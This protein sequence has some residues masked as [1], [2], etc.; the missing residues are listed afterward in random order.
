MAPRLPIP[1][2]PN[3]PKGGPPSSLRFLTAITQ[4]INASPSSQP[5]GN[6]VPLIYSISGFLAVFLVRGRRQRRTNYPAPLHV[7]GTGKC[8]LHFGFHRPYSGLRHFAG[9]GSSE[10]NWNRCG[11]VAFTPGRAGHTR[12]YVLGVQFSAP[13]ESYR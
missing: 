5:P 10:T 1:L 4:A 12:G 6:A 13:I 2:Q 9:E 3:M 7:K 8:L 11:L